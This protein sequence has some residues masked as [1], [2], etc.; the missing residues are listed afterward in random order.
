MLE[1]MEDADQRLKF[2]AATAD[3]IGDHAEVRALLLR[4]QGVA[5]WRHNQLDDAI[6]KHR[7]ALALDEKRLGKDHPGTFDSMMTLCQSLSIAFRY[8]E[9]RALSQRMVAMAERAFGRNHPYVARALIQLSEL[10]ARSGQTAEQSEMA[11]RAVEVLEKTGHAELSDALE[12]YGLALMAMV[13]YAEAE[14][15]FRR[16]RAVADQANQPSRAAGAESYLGAALG[17]LG[18]YDEAAAT[19][20]HAL[21]GLEK[22]YGADGVYVLPT[23]Y[24]IAMLEADRGRYAEALQAGERELRIAEATHSPGPGIGLAL[25]AVGRAQVGAR[26]FHGARAAL[27]RALTLLVP[28]QAR[29]EHRARAQLALAQAVWGDT[30][31][32]A[33]A[34]D[35]VSAALPVLAKDPVTREV[36]EKAQAFLDTLAR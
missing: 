36:A 17:H 33:R 32:R 21:A 23:L 9:A 15:V 25:F 2:A 27:E 29:P 3:R 18:R 4:N 31:D 24:R 22:A 1:H 20:G 5:A 11:G 34:R 28:G 6:A 16:A 13:R 7:E 12:K 8:E 19:L 30:R 26:Q 10:D 14:R 35:L